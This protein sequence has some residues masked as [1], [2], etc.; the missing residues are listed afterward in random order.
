MRTAK[1]LIRLG[2][3][4]GY[5][6]SSMGTQVILLF[7]SCSG[8]VVYSTRILWMHAIHFLLLNARPCYLFFYMSRSMTKPTKWHEHPAKTRIS[9]GIHPVW[10]EPSLCTL[11]IVKDPRFLHADSEDSDQTGW[12]PRLIWVFAGHTGHFVGFVMGR[13][14]YFFPSFGPGHAKMCL[15]PYTNNKGADQSAHP[16]SLISTFVFRCLDSII[17]LV[18]I[19]KISRLELVAVPEQNGLSHT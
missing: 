12:M 10:S 18:S 9:L 5:S 17:A 6:E 15:M 4:P 19:A 11:R 3:C 14:I 13:L 7:L 16:H 2:G 1:T 8:S